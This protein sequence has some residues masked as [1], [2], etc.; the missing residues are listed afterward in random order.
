MLISINRP[1]TELAK[2]CTMSKFHHSIRWTNPDGSVEEITTGPHD[3]MDAA[4]D[5]AIFVAKQFGWTEPNWWQ[6]WR[7]DD[8]RPTA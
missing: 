5:R 2:E 7:W 8:T 6:W 1:V 4:R 3:R